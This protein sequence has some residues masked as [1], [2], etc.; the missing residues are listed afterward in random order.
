[1]GVLGSGREG[2]QG[3]ATFSTTTHKLGAVSARQQELLLDAVSDISWPPSS[4]STVQ[5]SGC[6]VGLIDSQ[7]GATVSTYQDKASQLIQLCNFIIKSLCLEAELE[8]A[9]TSLQINLST[10]AASDS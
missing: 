7:I 2:L 3:P 9:W 1:M 8:F 5:G 4:R 6:A 10:I